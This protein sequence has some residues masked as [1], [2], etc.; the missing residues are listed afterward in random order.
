[1][2]PRRLPAEEALATERLVEE[3]GPGPGRL[4]E[5]E[6]GGV[7]SVAFVL[8]GWDVVICDTEPG[9]HERARARAP[10]SAEVV[11]ADADSLPFEDASFDVVV[12]A[13]ETPELLR[14]LRPTGRHLS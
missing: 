6:S 14:V 4:L 10:V 11:L 13:E 5:Y 7:H 9:L 12:A 2:R 3:A 1:M 8:A